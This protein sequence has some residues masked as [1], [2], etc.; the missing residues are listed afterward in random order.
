[1][2]RHHIILPDL[3]LGDQPLTLSLWLV[4]PGSRVAQGQPILEVLAGAATV[5]LPSP[6]DGI[7]VEILVDEDE[8][9]TVGQPLAVIETAD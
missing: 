5:D 3:G 7:L 4:A 2:A 9:I 1:M 8:P 6:A